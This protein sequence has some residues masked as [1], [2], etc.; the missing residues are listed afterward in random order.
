M[1]EALV[2]IPGTT[3]SLKW[4][5]HFAIGKYSAEGRVFVIKIPK[6]TEIIIPFLPEQIVLI[7]IHIP[8]EWIIDKVKVGN[9]ENKLVKSINN[10]INR[11]ITFPLL[12]AQQKMG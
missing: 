5:L 10:P 7:P 3:F 9:K 1:S 6:G 4:A 12:I 2:K 11:Y 8:D